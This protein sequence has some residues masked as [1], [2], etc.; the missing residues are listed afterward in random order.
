MAGVTKE[1]ARFVLH[2]IYTKRRMQ[3]FFRRLDEV[4][5]TLLGQ[6]DLRRFNCLD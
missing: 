5:Q 4:I 1:I 2:D 3:I 6:K